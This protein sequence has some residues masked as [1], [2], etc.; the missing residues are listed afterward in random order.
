MRIRHN[1]SLLGPLLIE[2]L[3]AEAGSLVL[4][5]VVDH[6]VADGVLA[7]HL[8]IGNTGVVKPVTPDNILNIK[9]SRHES[10]I[11]I[12]RVNILVACKMSWSG[13]LLQSLV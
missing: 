9:I 8:V 13:W 1:Y 3:G 7:A 12:N 6:V 10:C 2:S 11:T 4:E 5:H